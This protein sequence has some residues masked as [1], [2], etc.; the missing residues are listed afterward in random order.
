[1]GFYTQPTPNSIRRIVGDKEIAH[2][3][4]LIPAHAADIGS[5]IDRIEQGGDFEVIADEGEGGSFRVRVR[6]E[7]RRSVLED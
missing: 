2:V 6:R 3:Q 1:M 4:P 5:L 7:V